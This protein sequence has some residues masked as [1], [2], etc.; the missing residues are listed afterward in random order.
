MYNPFSLKGKNIL[1]TG[2]SSGIGE[3]CALILSKLGANLI[4]TGRNED[5]LEGVYQKLDPQGKHFISQFDM[6]EVE[7]IPSWIQGVLDERNIILDGFIYSAG[8]VKLSPIRTLTVSQM[9]TLMNVNLHAGIMLLKT[10]TNKRYSKD[11]S[12]FVFISSVNA[13]LGAPGNSIYTASKAAIDAMVRSAAVELS[14][15]VRVNSIAPGLVETPLLNGTP[16]KENIIRQ[17]P[18]GLGQPEDVAFAAAYLLSNA[19]RWVSG[20]TLTVDGGFSVSK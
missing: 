11:G 15:R 6:Q 19:S 9:N 12:S 8:I 5:R 7:Q 20:T 13:T 4:I 14:P 1:V 2:A 10:C 3:A 16:N 17:H 18:L